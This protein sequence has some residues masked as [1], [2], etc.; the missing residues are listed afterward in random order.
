MNYRYKT[1]QDFRRSQKP[2][3]YDHCIGSISSMPIDGKN[4]NVQVDVSSDSRS[5]LSILPYG[6]SSSPLKGMLS[7]TI[8]NNNQHVSSIGVFNRNRPATKP[9]ETILYNK[10]TARIVL[11]INN[12]IKIYNTNTSIIMD[13]SCKNISINNDKSHINISD[14]EISIDNDKSHINISGSAINMSNDSVSVNISDSAIDM[15]NGSSNV[16]ISNGGIVLSA[17]SVDINGTL[18]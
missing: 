9:G 2:K 3:S 11:D 13:E 8:N 18:F 14:S 15:S 12:N 4:P 7:Q 1:I 5:T 17:L 6:I 16:S 10:G